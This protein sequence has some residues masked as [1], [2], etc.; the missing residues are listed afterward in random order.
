[1][2]L[3]VSVATIVIARS[4]T[5]GQIGCNHHDHGPS[6]AAGEGRKL[7]DARAL[8]RQGRSVDEAEY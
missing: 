3:L 4:S 1:M 6:R 2:L 7:L 8:A 5:A